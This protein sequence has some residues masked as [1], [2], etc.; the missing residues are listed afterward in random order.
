MYWLDRWCNIL[1]SNYFF[2]MC[3]CTCTCVYVYVCVCVCVCVYVC[4]CVCV[5]AY[6]SG[7]K[8]NG[9][10]L[11]GHH[12]IQCHDDDITTTHLR[13]LRRWWQLRL[14]PRVAATTTTTMGVTSKY[15]HVF[16]RVFFTCYCLFCNETC[17]LL[18]QHVTNI[19]YYSLMFLG[20]FFI[21][22]NV[23]VAIL[24]RSISSRLSLG[25]K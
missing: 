5:C 2:C 1:C 6:V 21:Q 8:W 4:V 15:F 17:S 25:M 24:K 20:V 11:G 10:I 19:V 14:P 22:D 7:E 16:C 18:Q 9:K 13:L 23:S 3:M 12:D